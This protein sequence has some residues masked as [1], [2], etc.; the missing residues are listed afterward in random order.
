MH[1][2][3]RTSSGNKCFFIF[4]LLIVLYIYSAVFF[5]FQRIE[6]LPVEI[7][8]PLIVVWYAMVLTIIESSVS[9]PPKMVKEFL[10]IFLCAPRWL[11]LHRSP[12]I[13]KKPTE[14]SC[15]YPASR[16]SMHITQSIALSVQ[17]QRPRSIFAWDPKSWGRFRC[18]SAR[19]SSLASTAALAFAPV[20][21][22]YSWF[23]S[24]HRLTSRM[25][26]LLFAI[27]IL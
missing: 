3:K 15:K 22:F 18:V 5:F 17:V 23:C 7:H 8:E 16:S 1:I 6:N 25:P 19:E 20:F 4:L 27:M 2:T 26:R 11:R 10:V 24:L 21:A 9:L 13:L 12:W 14:I